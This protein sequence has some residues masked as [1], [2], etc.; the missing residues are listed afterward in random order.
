MTREEFDEWV[1]HTSYIFGPYCVEWTASYA[2]HYEALKSYTLEEMTKATDDLYISAKMTYY[3]DP[4]GKL[5]TLVP[6]ISEFEKQIRLNR[7]K[8][9]LASEA[10]NKAQKILNDGYD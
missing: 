3:L 10:K 1:D 2:H 4:K 7:I 8:E 9:I 6:T 5:L